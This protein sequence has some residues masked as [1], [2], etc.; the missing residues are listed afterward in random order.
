[1]LDIMDMNLLTSFVEDLEG[2]CEDIQEKLCLDSDEES[3]ES[4]ILDCI[5]QI[6]GAVSELDRLLAGLTIQKYMPDFPLDK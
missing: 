5:L 2:Q 6:E 4:E 3:V 1:M